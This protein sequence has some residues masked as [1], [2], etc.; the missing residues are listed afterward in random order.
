MPITD[1][2][3]ILLSICFFVIALLYASVGFAGGSGYLAVLSLFSVSFFAIRTI[4]LVCNLTV[5]TGGN[6]LYYKNGHFDLKKFMPFVVTSI[7]MAFIGTSFRLEEGMFFALLGLTLIISSTLFGSQI[8]RD[9]SIRLTARK[10]PIWVICLLGAGI[11]FLAGLVGI[12]GGIFLVPILNQMRW[13]YSIKIAA[14]ATF[15]ILV[16]SISGIAGLL[17]HDMFVVSW[18][19]ILLLMAAVL[20]GGQI[21]SRMSIGKL[22]G[23]RIKLTT[24]ILMFLIGIKVLLNDGLHLITI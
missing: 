9:R 4:A 17:V 24:A 2:N 16:N 14:L 10:Y 23:K 8:L 1:E 6:F 20:L 3:L 18:R 21:G 19:S 7:P 22:T 5:V 13:D 15:F 12:G 11:G